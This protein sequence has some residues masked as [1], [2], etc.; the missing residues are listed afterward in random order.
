MDYFPKDFLVIV[1]ESHQ[2]LPQVRGMFNGDRARKNTLVDYGFRLPSAL[3][4]RPLKFDEFQSKLNTAIYVSATPG[5]YELDRT[6]GV[7]TE[8]IIRPTG[9]ID[10]L[11]TVKK[12]EGQIDD[13]IS[14]IH[15]RKDKKQR[16]MITTVTKKMAEDLSEYLADKGIKVTYLHSEIKTFERTEI[17]NDLRRGKYDV[18]VGINLLREGLDIPEVGLV[19]ILDADKEGFLRSDKS[20]I[21]IVGRAA[22]N[23]EGEV[24]MYANTMTDSMKRA[25]EETNRRRDVQIKYNEEHGIIPKTIIKDIRE[26]I[27]PREAQEVAQMFA[28]KKRLTK[29][30]RQQKINDLRT[31]MKAAAKDLDFERAATLRDIIIELEGL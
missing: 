28:S 10:P 11:I 1:D 14:Q 15:I 25:I 22:R 4:N 23:A 17:I 7:I 30:E 3:D 12:T 13:L 21:Q 5:D 19:A 26:N 8:Q 31:E 9:L 29:L 24:I 6:M 27:N 18:L 2:M 16:T 20:L